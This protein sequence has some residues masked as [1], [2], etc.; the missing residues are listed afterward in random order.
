[1]ADR[2]GNNKSLIIAFS[3]FEKHL[4]DGVDRRDCIRNVIRTAETS[5]KEIDGYPYLDI[6]S[7]DGARYL[8]IDHNDTNFYTTTADLFG[9]V[10]MLHRKNM[11]Q[12]TEIQTLRDTCGDL[13]EKYQILEENLRILY[14]K[15]EDKEG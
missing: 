7:K 2:G 8:R 9:S 10:L 3:P 6:Y 5:I 11:D 13:K 12:D 1:M 4:E 14:E 15:M